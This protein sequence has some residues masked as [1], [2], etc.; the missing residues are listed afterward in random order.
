MKNSI[1]FW[2]NIFITFGPKLCCQNE[3]ILVVTNYAPLVEDLCL[4][5]Y[6]RDFILSLADNNQADK[7]NA[8]NS[9]SRHQDSLLNM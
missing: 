5:C 3:G 6:E 4:F 2:T 8:F 9:S 1:I 7:I